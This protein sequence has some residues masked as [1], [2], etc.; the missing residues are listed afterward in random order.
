MPVV[1][2]VDEPE[3]PSVKVNKSAAAAASQSNKSVEDTFENVV[4][5]ALKN[6]HPV[7]R[8]DLSDSDDDDLEDAE[9]SKGMRPDFSKRLDFTF[10]GTDEEQKK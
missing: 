10:M 7:R 9:E 3:Y 8:D 6:D 4:N 1:N 5:T 2:E